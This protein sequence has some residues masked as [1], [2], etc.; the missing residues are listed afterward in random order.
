MKNKQRLI[1]S[2]TNLLNNFDYD[3]VDAIYLTIL[4]LFHKQRDS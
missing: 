1:T 3:T 2:I 4:R